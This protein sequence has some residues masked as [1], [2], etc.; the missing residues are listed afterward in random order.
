MPTINITKVSGVVFMQ[1]GTQNALSYFNRTGKYV[2]WD[3]NTGATIYIGTDEYKIA[4]SDLQINGATP[5]NIGTAKILLNSIF[6][7]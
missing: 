2:V 4:L 1:S 3:D 5:P 7:T 6:G